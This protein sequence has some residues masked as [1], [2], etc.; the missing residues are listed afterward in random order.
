MCVCQIVAT[1][2]GLLGANYEHSTAEAGPVVA[3][4]DHAMSFR[5]VRYLPPMFIRSQL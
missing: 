2:D 3:M 1:R 4:L 5:Y